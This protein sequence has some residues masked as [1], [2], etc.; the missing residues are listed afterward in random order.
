MKTFQEI[1]RGVIEDISISEMI[2]A[3][4]KYSFADIE[5]M[6]AKEYA[7]QWVEKCI[8]EIVDV[9]PDNTV[10]YYLKQIDEQ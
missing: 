1:R 10:N 6:S 2:G 8:T 3:E 5:V 4:K 9:V 7:K